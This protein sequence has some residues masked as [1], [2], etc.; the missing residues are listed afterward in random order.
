MTN[1]FSSSSEF[2]AKDNLAEDYITI[3]TSVIGDDEFKESK[4]QSADVSTLIRNTTINEDIPS[5]REW[6]KK[7]LEEAEKQPG[8]KKLIICMASIKLHHHY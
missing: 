7:Q 6:T 2:I 8:M 4:L 1:N 3:K 5:F